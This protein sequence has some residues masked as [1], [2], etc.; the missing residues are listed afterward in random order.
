MKKT[1]VPLLVVGLAVILVFAGCVPGAP[2]VTPPPVTPPVEPVTPA[3]PAPEVEVLKLGFAAPL[4][5]PYA[6]YGIAFERGFNL[7][8]DM[9]NAEG[10]IEVGGVTY[11]L[12]GHMYDD[13]GFIPAEDRKCAVK[14]VEDGC[15]YLLSTPTPAVVEA[16]E[17]FLYEHGVLHLTWGVAEGH[18]PEWPNVLGTWTC[19]PQ[20]HTVP[21]EYL[22]TRYPE[23][24]RVAIAIGDSPFGEGDKLWGE[25]V[26]EA[27]GLDVVYSEFY[28]MET[29]DW[30]PL[31]TA[32]LA[33]DPDFIYLD[34]AGPAML[35]HMLATA[36]DLGY[37][38]KFY[39]IVWD[40]PKLLEK[41]PVDYIQG[42]IGVAAEL[43][44]P[45]IVGEPL[46]RVHSEYMDRWPEEYLID[47]YYPAL[48]YAPILWGMQQ[49]DSVDP[50]KVWET[51]LATDPVWNPLVEQ[52]CYWG[53]MDLI[54]CNHALN[55]AVFVAEIMGEKLQLVGAPSVADW[56]ANPEYKECALTHLEEAGLLYWQR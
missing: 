17:P 41:V 23:I 14:A 16:M 4:S 5:G 7:W 2:P 33:H 20:F 45:D 34:T 6:G 3:P 24:E 8:I 22:H 51:L 37:T 9:I 28:P 29:I 47:A 19:W 56:W 35:P 36:K 1:F 21:I 46:Y 32:M 40:I 13:K 31:F 44:D 27:Q 55:T 38:G 11:M 26:C 50:E 39:N 49:A 53:G 48:S 42:H 15:G 18:R 10:G 52:W 12:E 43:D 25:I 54:G 30:Y